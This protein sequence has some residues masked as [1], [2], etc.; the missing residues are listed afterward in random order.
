MKKTIFVALSLATAISLNAAVLASVNGKEITDD[1]LKAALGTND[2]SQ[3]P[4][5]AKKG[6][7]E[8]LVQRELLTQEAKKS[9]IQNTEEY[10]KIIANTADNIAVNLW[11]TNQ[12]KS[13]K[14]S[15]KEIND[16][17][18]A[19]KKS[20]KARHILVADEK[21]ANEIIASLSKLKGQQL[22]AKFSELAKA[23]STDTGS[24]A[25]GGDLG[26]FPVS[27]MVKPFSDA[28]FALKKGEITKAPVKTEFGYHIIIKDD[29][30]ELPPLNKIKAEVESNI[31]AG[32]HREIM[33][34]KIQELK[35][36][37]KVIYK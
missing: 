26:W 32:K 6:L 15:D 25:S 28:A 7:V 3:I 22:N 24:A 33:G 18:N 12:I 17:Y 23:K 2:L 11:M 9:G 1:T 36:S 10:K 20:I 8:E 34:Q 29:E 5:E 27:V 13:I 14:V 30:K 16:F 37:S 4:A 19:N 35:N 21:E 31:R